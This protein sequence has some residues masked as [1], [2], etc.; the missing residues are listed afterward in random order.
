MQHNRVK[1]L[2]QK[3]GISVNDLAHYVGC[4]PQTV[5][6]WES[7]VLRRNIKMRYFDK[8][9]TF[10][11][12]PIDEIVWDEDRISSII[13]EEWDK[14]VFESKCKNCDHYDSRDYEIFGICTCDNTI[15]R[16]ID[17]CTVKNAFVI[18]KGEKPKPPSFSKPKIDCRCGNCM[19]LKQREGLLTC[20]NEY[21]E[22]YLKAMG[23]SGACIKWT[24]LQGKCKYEDYA[25]YMPSKEFPFANRLKAVRE[26]RNLSIEEICKELDIPISQWNDYE[27]AMSIMSIDELTKF[28]TVSKVSIYFLLGRKEEQEL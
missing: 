3:N 20:I 13:F 16:Y 10:F 1:E 15:K 27:N 14:S 11:D 24:D 19:Y 9:S 22:N 6:A 17:D 18:C 21:S 5:N 28:A 25:Q 23:T 7:P 2:R 26:L 12:L 4:S 8:L